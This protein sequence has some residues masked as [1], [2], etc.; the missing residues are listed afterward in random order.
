MIKAQIDLPL[1][2][3]NANLEATTF[4][5]YDENDGVPPAASH[6]F[7]VSELVRASTIPEDRAVFKIELPTVARQSFDENFR[8]GSKNMANC[9]EVED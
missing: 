2:A 4:H 8:V 7:L 9:T 3:S 1:L 5:V 6:K